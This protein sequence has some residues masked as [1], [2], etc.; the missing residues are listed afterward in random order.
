MWKRQLNL[1][2]PSAQWVP[3]TINAGWQSQQLP[4]AQGGK[5][6]PNN[7]VSTI[8]IGQVAFCEP[9]SNPPNVGIR[10][11]CYTRQIDKTLNPSEMAPY[12]GTFASFVAWAAMQMG[13]GKNYTLNVSN[14]NAAANNL[15]GSI[16]AQ[17]DILWAIQDAY[18]PNIAAFVDDDLL[19]VKDRNK[20]LDPAS[21][22]PINT[23]I[24]I[25]S[26]YEYGVQFETLFNPTVRLAQGVSLTSV[27]NPSINN[28][29]PNSAYVVMD[30]EYDLSSRD[31]AFYVKV[32]AC[33]PA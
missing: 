15:G 14:P 5:N 18:H 3:V 4:G 6:N 30:L 32:Y 24:G 29:G 8:F 13:F 16:Y 11:T 33:P 27:L 22:Q 10:I 31:E 28:V 9:I 7:N 25:P 2:N 21:T 20:I 12:S 23:F 1:T 17:S 19:I 26:W